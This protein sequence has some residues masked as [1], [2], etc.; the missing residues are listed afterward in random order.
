MAYNNYIVALQGLRKSLED[1][2]DSE[3]EECMRGR[4]NSERL[5]DSLLYLI[6]DSGVLK[7]IYKEDEAM[8]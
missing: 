5:K 7:G 4:G 8:K 2:I 6:E 3:I 1:R